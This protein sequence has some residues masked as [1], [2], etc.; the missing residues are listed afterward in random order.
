[1]F[2]T[3]SEISIYLAVFSSSFSFYPITCEAFPRL[4]LRR[5]IVPRNVSINVPLSGV[6]VDICN[7]TEHLSSGH[8]ILINVYNIGCANT[9]L[10]ACVCVLCRYKY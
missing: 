10:K 2:Y 1:M 8:V 3:K 7:R 9:D 4:L 5:F 6:S